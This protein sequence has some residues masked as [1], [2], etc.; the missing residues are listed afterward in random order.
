MVLGIGE[1]DETVL[2][3]IVL[4]NNKS[5][6]VL[7]VEETNSGDVEEVDVVFEGNPEGAIVLLLEV[8]L[9]LCLWSPLV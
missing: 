6:L 9:R 7:L 4:I 3:V 1:L 8:N 5:V 2:L